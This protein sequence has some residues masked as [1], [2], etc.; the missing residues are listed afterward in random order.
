M[1]ELFGQAIADFSLIILKIY[2]PKKIN[3]HA[4]NGSKGLVVNSGKRFLKKAAY[5]VLS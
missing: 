4:K 3:R 5:T 2:F 1:V